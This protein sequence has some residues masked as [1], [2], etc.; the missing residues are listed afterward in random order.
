MIL[1][2]VDPA[3]L[4]LLGR[5]LQ[6]RPEMRI[7]AQDSL[8]HVWFRDLQ[9]LRGQSGGGMQQGHQQTQPQQQQQMGAAMAGMQGQPIGMTAG[10]Y[11][12]PAYQ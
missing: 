11:G 12:M 5:C 4:D 6:L 8:Q 2:T 7:S 1:P 9:Q 3:A 10:G